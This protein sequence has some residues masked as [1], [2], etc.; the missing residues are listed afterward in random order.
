MLTSSVRAERFVFA[1]SLAWQI[2]AY[3]KYLGLMECAERWRHLRHRGC[4]R[5]ARSWVLVRGP[6]GIPFGA[7]KSIA[8]TASCGDERSLLTLTLTKLCLPVYGLAPPPSHVGVVNTYVFRAP[9]N[10]RR[11]DSHEETSK[12]MWRYTTRHF[13]RLTQPIVRKQ[14]DCTWWDNQ[15]CKGADQTR[16]PHDKMMKCVWKTCASKPFSK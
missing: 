5:F 6:D 1:A 9:A 2:L 14:E 3:C 8:E 16:Q 15:L 12:Q 10:V 13:C 7:F 11:F 4:G